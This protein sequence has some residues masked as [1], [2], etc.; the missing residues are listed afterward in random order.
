M[1]FII[2][3][4]SLHVF[5][6]ALI[7][8]FNVCGGPWGVEEVVAPLGP[9]IGILSLVLFPIIFSIPI[10]NMTCTMSTRFPMNGGYSIWVQKA[11]GDFWGFQESFWHYA[12]GVTDN[13]LYP[14][15]VYQLAEPFIGVQPPVQRYFI[16]L[17]IALLF[18]LPTLFHVNG[19]TKVMKYCVVIVMIPFFVFVVM[20]CFQDYEPARLMQ[21]ASVTPNA[22]RDLMMVLYWNY[23]GFDCASAFSN[24]IADI[25]NT[26]R[27]GLYIALVS[28]ILTYLVPVAMGVMVTTDWSVWGSDPGDCAW[29]CV[30]TQIGGPYLGY[31]ILLSSTVG[32]LGLYMAELFE[33]AWQ[34]CGMSEAG[35]IPKT[36]SKRHALYGTPIHASMFSILLISILVYFDFTDNLVMN[37]F[38]NAAGTVLEIAAYMHFYGFKLSMVFPVLITLYV[39]YTA[40]VPLTGLG[41]LVGVGLYWRFGVI[42]RVMVCCKHGQGSTSSDTKGSP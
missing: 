38:F 12:S 28:S 15:F 1:L 39:L 25:E 7:T 16:K 6:V 40:M 5:H 19:F 3:M 20:S 24:E 4:K 29:S 32:A 36:F 42:K 10:I 2:N 14:G 23:G 35:L 8:F 26:M 17:I 41:V 27:K 9:S 37:N 22:V 21:T 33:D 34:L 11:F 31:A 30:V 13:A 18:A